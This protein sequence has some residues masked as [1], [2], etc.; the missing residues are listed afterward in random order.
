VA[1]KLVLAAGADK[2]EEQ[3]EAMTYFCAVIN[4]SGF[5][6]LLFY[7]LMKFIFYFDLFLKKV[8]IVFIIYH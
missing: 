5:P 7:C 8:V 6:S 2:A 4:E 1:V 3:A